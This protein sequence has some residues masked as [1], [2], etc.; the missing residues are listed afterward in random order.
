MEIN[1][2]T[3]KQIYTGT[4]NKVLIFVIPV[5]ITIYNAPLIIYQEEDVQIVESVKDFLLRI[6]S[7]LK[8]L[9]RKVK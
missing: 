9:C 2:S 6:I 3:I 8:Y 7:I 4:F 5:R 1:I